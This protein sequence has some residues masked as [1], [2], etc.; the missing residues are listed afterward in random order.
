MDSLLN[1]LTV[2]YGLICA[3]VN[4]F[5]FSVIFYVY[6]P[7]TF[8]SLK[9]ILK[10]INITMNVAYLISAGSYLFPIHKYQISDI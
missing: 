10:A 3:S 9:Y 2:L 7:A 6:L 5:S 4:A 8:L 1:A